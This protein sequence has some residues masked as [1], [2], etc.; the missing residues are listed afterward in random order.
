MRLEVG[1]VRKYYP[2]HLN[3]ASCLLKLHCF[4]RARAIIEIK[5]YKK[6]NSY[7]I[8]FLTRQKAFI[9]LNGSVIPRHLIILGLTHL[10]TR[11][12]HNRI[13]NQLDRSTCEMKI[14]II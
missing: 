11:K 7:V 6:S 9:F 5:K 3:I 2:W 1:N 8:F 14:I 10:A 12:I 13:Q 4:S